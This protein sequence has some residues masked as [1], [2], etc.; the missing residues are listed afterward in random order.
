MPRINIDDKFFADHRFR[1]LCELIGCYQTAIGVS[2]LFWQL[3]QQY[4]K[5]GKP[6]PPKVFFKKKYAND[7]L[8]V[9]LARRVRGGIY[10]CG[11]R[12]HFAWIQ[13]KVDAINKRWKS[14][15]NKNTDV[16]RNDTDVIPLAPA[17]D[18]LLLNKKNKTTSIT[19]EEDLE[20]IKNAMDRNKNKKI[21][22]D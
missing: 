19:S 8:Q 1:D 14:L 22:Y 5:N 4:F 11:S 17:L 15:K 9:G 7:F 21:F 12:D 20:L 6:I 2:V 3:G 18:K 10:I 16:L 13:Q